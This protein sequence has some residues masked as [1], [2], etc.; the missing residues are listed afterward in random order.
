MARGK[1]TDPDFELFAQI[2]AKSKAEGFR[3]GY[4]RALFDMRNAAY[5][6]QNTFEKGE[7][8]PVAPIA[9]EVRAEPVTTVRATRA[10]RANSDQYR[11]FCAIVAKPGLRGVEIV[12]TLAQEDDPVHERTVRTALA[13]LKGKRIEQ[14]D[15]GWYPLP[16]TSNQTS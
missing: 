12:Q 11:V 3:E 2:K 5:N 14:R 10:P 1:K 7:S 15:G 9:G 13:R 8:R 16:V 4:R 6:L